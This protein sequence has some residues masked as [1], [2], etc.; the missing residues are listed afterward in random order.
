M[1]TPIATAPETTVLRRAGMAYHSPHRDDVV[2]RIL[3]RMVLYDPY[4]AGYVAS[5]TSGPCK[6]LVGEECF[7][8]F[9]YLLPKEDWESAT[10]EPESVL[11]VQ[12]WLSDPGP[13]VD[14]TGNYYISRLSTLA[15]EQ[16]L[17]MLDSGQLA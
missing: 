16:L 7:H 2:V 1:N 13:E 9:L 4:G 3:A 12:L 6:L 11:S 8:L 14:R 5:P 17:G 15:V 10:P